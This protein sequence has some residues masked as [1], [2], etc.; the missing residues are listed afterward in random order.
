MGSSFWGIASREAMK[1]GVFLTKLCCFL[2]VTVNYLGF[3]AFSYG[4]SMIP[5]LH[6]SGNVVLAERIS[7]R[8]RKVGRGDIVVVRSPENPRVAPTKRV[9]GV[10]GDLI[11]YVIDP[12]KN[13]KSQSIVVPKGHVWVQGDYTCNSKDSRTFGPVPYALIQGRVLLRVWPFRDFGPLGPS[14]P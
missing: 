14:P 1:G 11:T 4:P 9:I 7:A 5:T 8:F 6:P 12:G 10:E 2:N 3:V 13:D